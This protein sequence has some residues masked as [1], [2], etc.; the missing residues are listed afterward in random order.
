MIRRPSGRKAKASYPAVKEKMPGL[1][2]AASFFVT[3][4]AVR[5]SISPYLTDDDARQGR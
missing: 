2:P 3:L 5:K 4:F 1:M